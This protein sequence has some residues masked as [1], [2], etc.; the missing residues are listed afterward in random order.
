MWS[1]VAGRGKRDIS[2]HRLLTG[3]RLVLGD[4][5]RRHPAAV[6]NVIT[7][8]ACPGP[9]LSGVQRG[10]SPPAGPACCAASATGAAAHLASVGDVLADGRAQ[11]LRVLRVDVVDEECLNLLGHL[12]FRLPWYRQSSYSM[13]SVTG[14]GSTP[15]HAPTAIA[16]DR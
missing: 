5:V 15:S 1:R 13:T 7:L 3:R 8:L 10:A 11:L 9:D 12:D 16:G 4:E 14:A 2:T 6:L